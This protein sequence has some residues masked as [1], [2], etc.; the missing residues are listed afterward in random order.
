[1]AKSKLDHGIIMKALD[2]AYDKAI[3]GVKG[4]DSAEEIALS[5][6]NNDKDIN[7]NTDALIRWQI[8]KAGTSGFLT[9][10]GGLITLPIAIPANVTSVI[11]IQVRMI[12]AIA[13]IGGYDLKDDKVKTLVFLCMAGSG[14]KEILKDLGIALGARITTKLIESISS[15]AIIAINQ[16]VGFKL[17]ATFGEKGMINLGKAVPLVG[18]IIGGTFDSIST[19]VIGNIAKKTFISPQPTANNDDIQIIE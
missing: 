10:L 7:T 9:G 2:Y 3:G 6:M 4:L 8:S 5:Y 15:K 11:Y 17:L 1:M 14:A 18:G 19:N 16:K 12:A 13:Y